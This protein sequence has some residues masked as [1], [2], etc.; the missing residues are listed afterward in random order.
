MIDALLD[1]GAYQEIKKVTEHINTVT[2]GNKVTRY[3]SNMIVNTMLSC[4]MQKASA[5]NVEVH[6]GYCC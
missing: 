5:L 4:M 3:C 2:D 6:K 1:Q